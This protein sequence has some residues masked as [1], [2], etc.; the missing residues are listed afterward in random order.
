[1]SLRCSLLGHE[2]GES[3]IERDREERGNEVV[4]SVVELERCVHCGTART[5]SENT[6]VTQ[7][8]GPRSG[9]VQPGP[10]R[11]RPSPAESD[12]PDEPDEP[13]EPG[14]IADPS[15]PGIE[16]RETSDPADSTANPAN[17][18]TTRRRDPVVEADPDRED[19][20][21]IEDGPGTDEGRDPGAWPEADG[22]DEGFDATTP[23]GPTDIDFGGGLTPQADQGAEIIDSA[24]ESDVEG[25]AEPTFVDAGSSQSPGRSAPPNVG[26]GLYCPHCEAASLDERDSLRAGD[27]CP[28]CHRG[29]L[30][31]GER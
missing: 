25:G 1:M 10:A 3:E 13:G 24:G 18:E 4:I 22:E 31:E 23:D 9:T 20:E 5:I 29:Y 14:E 2:Y 28:E 30:A 11:A 8:S 21:I 26:G 7:L 27:I 19:T 15:G 16:P 12:E 17:S 6:E